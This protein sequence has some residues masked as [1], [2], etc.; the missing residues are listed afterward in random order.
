MIKPFDVK[1][2][3]ARIRTLTRRHNGRRTNTIHIGPACLNTHH[4]TLA[5]D[6]KVIEFS[7]REYSL[8]NA[9]FERP[10]QVLTREYLES[11]A[12]SWDEEIESNSLEVHI[13]HLR[14]KIGNDAIKTVRGVGYVIVEGYFE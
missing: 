13:H 8:I 6:S 7:R 1:E 4:R 9:F 11:T 10:R 12:Y 14:K 2:L 3:E 5:I